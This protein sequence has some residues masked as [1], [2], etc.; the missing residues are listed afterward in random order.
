[1]TA[2][3]VGSPT[4]LRTMV[5]EAVARIDAMPAAERTAARIEAPP[6]PERREAWPLT[7]GRFVSTRFDTY[8]P[9]TDSERLALRAAQRFA[10]R[11]AAGEGA[12]LALLG[13][14]GSGKS[15]LL[16]SVAAELRALGVGYY[17]RPWYR[18]ADE[19]RY[20]GESP[21]GGASEEADGCRRLLWRSRRVILLDEVDH[22]S[23]TE[24]DGLEMKKLA[25]H[26][27]DNQLALM[28][29]SPLAKLADL[30][31]VQAASRFVA[32]TIEGRDRRQG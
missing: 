5:T 11:A 7:P 18:L 12:M 25:H 29:T 9:E 3:R 31:G 21:F 32:V 1:M 17:S 22:T 26:A 16:Y 14:T 27:W 8:E 10:G 30:M 15:H 28:L 2:P 24:F 23:G 4:P 19:L 20:G 13:T 6:L